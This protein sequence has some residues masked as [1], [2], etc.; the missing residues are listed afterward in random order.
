M[1][2]W[3]AQRHITVFTF[4]NCYDY[5]FRCIWGTLVLWLSWEPRS[6]LDM[7][8][9]WSCTGK[10]MGE[11]E[12]IKGRT[13]TWQS[14]ISRLC[15]SQSQLVAFSIPQRLYILALLGYLPQLVWW[16]ETTD[17]CHDLVL[18][19]KAGRVFQADSAQG[20]ECSGSSVKCCRT[21]S[22]WFLQATL[23]W[24]QDNVLVLQ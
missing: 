13:L 23:C 19:H 3:R 5:L 20:R 15:H 21:K 16:F 4:C 22:W 1:V 17:A 8:L 14:H 7:S 18:L 11:W 12:T 6:C 10:T 2:G 24:R 9:G